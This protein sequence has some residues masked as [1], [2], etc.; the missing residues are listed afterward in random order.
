M[1]PTT[2]S[3]LTLDLE[4]KTIAELAVLDGDMRELPLWAWEK[5]GVV[6]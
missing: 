2:E 4:K 1:N 6:V 5:W 3:V